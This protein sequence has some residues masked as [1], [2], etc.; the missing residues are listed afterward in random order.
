M[1]FALSRYDWKVR[2]RLSLE[3]SC[4]LLSLRRPGRLTD[5]VNAWPVSSNYPHPISTSHLRCFAIQQ[6]SPITL[7]PT[8]AISLFTIPWHPHH[9]A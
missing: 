2:R 1:V 6:G 9:R 4:C 8:V 7:P 5:V 3:A